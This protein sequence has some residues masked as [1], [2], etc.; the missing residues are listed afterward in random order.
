M[1]DLINE[2]VMLLLLLD[3]GVFVLLDEEDELL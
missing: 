2:N 3:G 1:V